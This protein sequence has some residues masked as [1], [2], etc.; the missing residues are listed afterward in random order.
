MCVVNVH[1][2]A[3]VNIENKTSNISHPCLRYIEANK[4]REKQ[5]ATVVS[6]SSEILS[7]DQY[8]ALEF[9]GIGK[10]QPSGQSGS[11]RALVASW[12]LRCGT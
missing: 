2:D 9:L 7:L 12:S 3:K 1:N 4:C 5:Y 11:D 6:S 10:T 8:W